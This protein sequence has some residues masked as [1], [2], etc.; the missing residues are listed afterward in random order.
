MTPDDFLRLM[1]VDKKNIDGRLR[2]V[3][4]RS[5]GEAVITGEAD[6]VYLSETLTNYCCG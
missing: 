2:L 3:A 6:P 5:L 1:A 4:L